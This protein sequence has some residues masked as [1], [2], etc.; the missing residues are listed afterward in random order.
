MRIV[1]IN[2]P[3]L[4]LSDN[5]GKVK[6]NSVYG[7]NR[8][9]D[10]DILVM[11][12]KNIVFNQNDLTYHNTTK[13]HNAV[14]ACRTEIEEHLKIGK[15]LIVF[16][17]GQL[18]VVAHQQDVMLITHPMEEE[19]V[20]L[21][22]LVPEFE[23]LIVE[24]KTGYNI[25]PDKSIESLYDTPAGADSL[26]EYKYVIDNKS[27]DFSFFKIK[28]SQKIVAGLKF[29]KRGRIF[30]LPDLNLP[31]KDRV[32]AEENTFQKVL[33]LVQ[34]VDLKNPNLNLYEEPKWLQQF[35]ILNQSELVTQK[36]EKEERKKIIEA[37]ITTINN[38]L[39]ELKM[40]KSILNISGIQLERQLE[41]MFKS[42]GFEVVDTDRNNRVDLV[43]S[44]NK[45]IIVCEIKGLT[46][47]AG[48]RYAVQLEKWV[49]DYR[50]EYDVVPMGLLIVSGY[51]EIPILERTNPIFPHA[52]LSYVEQRNHACLSTE[53]FLKLYVQF[54]EG[55]LATDEIWS[56]LY[57]SYGIVKE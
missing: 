28:K 57:N 54:K 56:K 18:N 20:S 36:K 41:E 44:H 25:V 53:T 43:L 13:F 2:G 21:K 38:S 45:E 23:N 10:A 6:S 16:L 34:S 11:S 40:A 32:T 7:H 27:I 24:M 33:S 17:G 12:T 49:S 47:S 26:F 46:G 52:M 37:E 29:Y 42:V 55:T 8:I 15:D 3:Y 19:S 9:A 5:Y 4:C 50:L 39:Y 22:K 30:F 31:I 1:Q 14:V 48:E 35:H 51:R